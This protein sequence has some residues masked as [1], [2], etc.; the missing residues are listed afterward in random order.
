MRPSGR[1]EKVNGKQ[2][3]WTRPKSLIDGLV[4]FLRW[5]LEAVM[6]SIP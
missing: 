5:L 3:K 2:V 1:R 4:S 6:T